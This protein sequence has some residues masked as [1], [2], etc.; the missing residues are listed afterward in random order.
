MN[1]LVACEF[2]GIVRNAFRARGH[3]AW[4]NDILQT[5]SEGNHYQCDIMESFNKQN[6]DLVIMHLP[7]TKI[8]LCGNSTYGTGM[9]KHHER[10]E[11]IKWTQTIW[12]LA[13]KN[14]EKVVFENPKNVM[15]KYIG[16]RTQVI[17]PYQFGHPERKE[18]WLWLK[19]LPSLTE[20]NYVFNEMM[21]LPR[22]KRERLHYMSPSETRG[23]ER[24]RTFTGIA[25]AMATQWN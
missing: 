12:E 10:I 7:C 14:F 6:W 23:H 5:E 24:S 9:I 11:A 19:G 15:G 21:A 16:K 17:H 2:S 20:T 4:S 25:E 22:N 13:V 18:T 8:A 3:N 1:V